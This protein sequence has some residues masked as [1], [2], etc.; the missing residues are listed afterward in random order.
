METG[1]SRRL[2][3]LASLACLAALAMLLVSTYESTPGALWA[4]V[5]MVLVSVA[6]ESTYP[7]L[8]GRPLNLSPSPSEKKTE[9]S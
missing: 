7:R 6:F 2:S 9:G 5:G 8:T 1:G 4:V 3:A